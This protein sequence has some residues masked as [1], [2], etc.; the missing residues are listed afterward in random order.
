M[1]AH[2]RAPTATEPPD[3]VR[4]LLRFSDGTERV[5]YFLTKP[6]N[7]F[8]AYYFD[9]GMWDSRLDAVPQWRPLS[10]EGT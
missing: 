7:G 6:T 5:G 10:A 4:V 1:S 8:R 3:S 2:F 9:N